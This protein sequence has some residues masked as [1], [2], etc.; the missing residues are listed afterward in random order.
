MKI[1]KRALA[2]TAIVLTSFTVSATRIGGVQWN[3]NDP[4]DFKGVTGSLYQEV[5]GFG[6]LS[7]YGR[8]TSFNEGSTSDLCPGCELTFHFGGFTPSVADAG[9]TPGLEYSGGWMKLW[10]DYSIEVVNPNAISS[11][12][13]VTTGDDGGANELW[14]ELEGHEY[15]GTETTF[16]GQLFPNLLTGVGFF[17]VVGGLAMWH[18]NTNTIETDGSPVEGNADLRFTSSFTDFPSEISITGT[19]NFKGDSIPEPTTLGIFALGLIALAI[20]V[21][22]KRV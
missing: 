20:K 7:G 18:F 19:A 11:M 10:V 21:H 22:N 12:D 16:I 14:L 17:D 9:V 8:I 4:V 3:P 13:F 6:V 5:D 1:V 2:I 15:I